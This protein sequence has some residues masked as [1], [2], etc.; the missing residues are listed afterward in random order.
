MLQVTAAFAAI[1][2]KPHSQH[3][4]FGLRVNCMTFPGVGSAG[5]GAAEMPTTAAV[6]SASAKPFASSTCTCVSLW[7]PVRLAMYIWNLSAGFVLC[8]LGTA[9]GFQARGGAIGDVYVGVAV[10]NHD[11]RIQIP[12]CICGSGQPHT[13]VVSS[14]GLSSAKVDHAAAWW[15][16]VLRQLLLRSQRHCRASTSMASER[17][18]GSRCPTS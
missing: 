9:G 2:G 3:W 15:T 8:S 14:H 17:M 16:A 11:R 12:V 4:T 6:Y 13:E 18:T 5:C 7:K 10:M 1:A